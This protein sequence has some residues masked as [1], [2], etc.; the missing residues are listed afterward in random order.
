[1]DA[2]KAIFDRRTI[3]SF[4]KRKVSELI[5]RKSLEAANQAPCHRLTFPWRFYSVANKKRIQMLDLAIELKSQKKQLDEK[6]KNIIRDK[7]LNPSHFIIASQ[8]LSSDKLTRKEDY[9]A[10]AC[11]IQNLSI[12]LT[13]EG[14]FTK[15]STGEITRDPKT[16]TITE[17]DPQKEEIIGFIWIGYGIKLPNIS[18]PSID[19]I[20]K[21]I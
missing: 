5:I 16:Y 14:V 4:E 20:Y 2:N 8:T 18:R 9:A 19:Q 10:C 11:A 13:T 7:F 15:W 17:I 6:T 12:S 21:E 3:H 1:M